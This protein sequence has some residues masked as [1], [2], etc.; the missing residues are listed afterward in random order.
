MRANS[1]KSVLCLLAVFTLT[2]LTGCGNYEETSSVA[3]SISSA[4]TSLSSLT[5]S[6][7]VA[8]STQGS[9]V[10]SS[11]V[12]SSA[13]AE[14][15]NGKVAVFPLGW[16]P[17]RKGYIL[18]DEIV[19][20]HQAWANQGITTDGWDD[21]TK[22]DDTKWT[23]SFADNIYWNADNFKIIPNYNGTN[24]TEVLTAAASFIAQAQ[25]SYLAINTSGLGV[26]SNCQLATYSPNTKIIDGCGAIT[27]DYQTGFNAGVIDSMIAY[28][29]SY[30]GPS[31]AMLYA[32]LE[33]KAIS[34]TPVSLDHPSW[35]VNSK[36]LF[37][38]MYAD[39]AIPSDGSLT[40]TALNPLVT[41]AQMDAIFESS[42]DQATR[43][44]AF[45]SYLGKSTYQDLKA[46]KAASDASVAN[47]GTKYKIGVIHTGE[48][49]AASTMYNNYLKY[50]IAP[51]YN[52]EFNF[53]SQYYTAGTNDFKAT[54]DD[55]VNAGC[56]AVMI[57]T[58]GS[59]GQRLAGIEEAIAKK[60]YV[61][62][63]ASSTVYEDEYPTIKTAV[64]NDADYNK[65]FVGAC[66]ASEASV[67]KL[68]SDMLTT[69]MDRV[70]NA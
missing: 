24:L 68:T 57:N 33:G 2:A 12:V 1:K 28:Y 36:E 20:F 45:Q 63:G 69:V 34:A 30:V 10:V 22:Y 41:K 4:A 47:S 48:T 14:P 64:N 66:S 62:C 44:A 8:S 17:W 58:D 18:N 32:A 67:V 31:F 25:P 39:T 35:Y 61:I 21:A 11:E 19:G 27:S 60:V 6:S 29:S 59:A 9:S 65:Y 42:S 37:N 7:V 38:N 13:V 3:A 26:Y 43:L 70:K 40:G 16:E 53:Q 51:L 46:N 5:P 55:L 52:V 56:D 15:K 54:V 23:V 50:Y 49:D